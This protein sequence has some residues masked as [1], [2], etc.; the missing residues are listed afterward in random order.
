MWLCTNSSESH[1]HAF[2]DAPLKLILFAQDFIDALNEDM[3]GRITH[4]PMTMTSD[5]IELGIWAANKVHHSPHIGILLISSKQFDIAVTR[6][7]NQGSRIL[8]DIEQRSIL[9]YRWLKIINAV[10]LTIGKV[11]DH[12]STERYQ[13]SNL[14]GIYPITI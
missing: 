9:V 1:P 4:C 3:I 8:S 6:Y 12:L 5:F 11:T 10:H 13:T 14:V 2:A 7:Q